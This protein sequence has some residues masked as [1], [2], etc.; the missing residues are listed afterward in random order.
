MIAYRRATLG[1]PD[2][3]IE[4]IPTVKLRQYLHRLFL[5]IIHRD[6]ILVPGATRTKAGEAR[7]RLPGP[8]FGAPSRGGTALDEN[9]GLYENDRGI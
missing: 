8:S 3:V 7:T 1:Y 5:W 9:A 4:S 6:L 2:S